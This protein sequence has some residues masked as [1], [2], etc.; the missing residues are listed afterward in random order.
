MTAL[1]NWLAGV[2]ATALV[3]SMMQMAVPK[4]TFQKIVRLLSG[5]VLA[6]V[7][8]Q[9]VL[10]MEFSGISHGL[11][12]AEEDLQE[13]TGEYRR[14]MLTRESDIIAAETAAY[15]TKTADAMGIVCTAEVRS[16]IVDDVPYP[17]EVTLDIPYH[18]ELSERI[19]TELAIPREKQHWQGE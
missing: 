1:K 18:R 10:Q 6:I 9:P 2:F 15:I 5:I 8:I 7:L 14:E 12:D 3:L 11:F 4:G 17:S 16:E 13:K 19:G